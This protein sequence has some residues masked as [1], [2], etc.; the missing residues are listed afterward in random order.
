MCLDFYKDLENY[1]SE[2]RYSQQ[3]PEIIHHFDVIDELI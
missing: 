1:I 2:N 3:N